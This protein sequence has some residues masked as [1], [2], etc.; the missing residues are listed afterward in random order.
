MASW[1]LVNIGLGKDLLP[2]MNQCWL[3]ISDVLWH[4]PEGNF[5]ENA[6]DIYPCYEFD[7]HLS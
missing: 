3:I 5:A 1:A 4:S 2:A 6:Q 7:I